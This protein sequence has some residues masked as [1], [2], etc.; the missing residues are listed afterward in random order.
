MSI[1]DFI[2]ACVL[3]VVTV[4]AVSNNNRRPPSRLK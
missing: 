4:W 2:A 1:E 3:V